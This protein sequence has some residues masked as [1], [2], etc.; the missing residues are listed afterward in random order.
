MLRLYR[1]PVSQSKHDRRVALEAR[2]YEAKG[3]SVDAD[4]SGYPQPRTINGYRPDVVAEKGSYISIVEVE[5]PDTVH[6]NHA[7]A[8]DRAFRRACRHNY[9]WHYRRI[10]TR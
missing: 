4:V 1:N 7:L 6:T 3:Y 9:N 2:S 8:Q 10:I 5:T